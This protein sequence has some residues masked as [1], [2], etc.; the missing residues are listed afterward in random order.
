MLVKPIDALLTKLTT[1]NKY[2]CK[3]LIILKLAKK[4]KRHTIIFY[5]TVIHLILK[6]DSD[7]DSD[8]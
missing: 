2:Y 7:P 6:P 3:S 4:F 1:A 5:G 8:S